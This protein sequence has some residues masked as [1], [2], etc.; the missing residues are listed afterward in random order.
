MTF[1]DDNFDDV[2]ELDDDDLDLPD[3]V[4]QFEDEGDNPDSEL[5]EDEE[6]ADL[7]A[8]GDD[9]D[10]PDSD[11]DYFDRDPFL[12]GRSGGYSDWD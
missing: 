6:W 11:P 9:I 10:N 5:E 4:V 7:L 1:A 8:L 2:D 12:R 3:G